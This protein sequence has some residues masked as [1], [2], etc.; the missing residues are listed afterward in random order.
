MQPALVLP[1]CSGQLVRVTAKQQTSDPRTIEIPIRSRRSLHETVEQARCR[2]IF[3]I[4]EALSADLNKNIYLYKSR[5]NILH[6][7]HLKSKTNKLLKNIAYR[8]FGSCGIQ[9]DRSFQGIEEV[10]LDRSVL[11]AIAKVKL[12]EWKSGQHYYYDPRWLDSLAQLSELVVN[13]GNDLVLEEDSATS[14]VVGRACVYCGRRCPELTIR[15]TFECCLILS[16]VD[17]RDGVCL[18]RG[19]SDRCRL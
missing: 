10:V 6:Q 5:I 18:R 16:G 9:Y 2:V 14:A 12:C 15:L 19:W 17:E 11:E 7:F 3:G 1:D 13:G 4:A 8:I